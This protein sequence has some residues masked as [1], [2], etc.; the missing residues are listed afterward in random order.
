M[1]V[2]GNIHRSIICAPSTEDIAELQVMIRVY[3]YTVQ[4]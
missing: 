4:C 2:L 3:I 1:S